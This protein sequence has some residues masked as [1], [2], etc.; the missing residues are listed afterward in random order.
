MENHSK[1]TILKMLRELRKRG[2]G[3]KQFN[4]MYDIIKVS[5]CN[6]TLITFH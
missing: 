4:K 3:N 6:L 2:K 5:N 1:I